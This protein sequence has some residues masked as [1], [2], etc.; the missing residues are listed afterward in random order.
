VTEAVASQVIPVSASDGHRWELIAR[1]PAR[2]VARVLW[3]PALGVPARN[4]LPLADALAARGVACYVHEWRGLGASSLRASR[5]CNWSY[6]E[7]LTMDLPA[8]E[9]ALG[10]HGDGATRVLGGHSLGGQLA[11]CLLALAPARSDAL[12][13]VGSGSPYWHAFPPPLRFALPIAYRFL[14]WLAQRCGA[15][16]GPRVGFGGRE[17]R[18]VIRDWSR[19]A[20]SGRY[21]A[22]GAADLDA[23]MAAIKVP[24]RAVVMDS[25]WMAP[26]SS[27]AFLASK[28]PRATLHVTTLDAATLGTRS[29]HFSWMRQPD[30]VA[31]ALLAG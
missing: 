8:S 10:A 2:P 16:P 23:R 5:K 29:D 26:R 9:A 19:S 27:L 1:V 31:D 25:D 21:R 7:L 3:L 12:W 28:M 30:A 15:L 18:D 17:A 14:P 20:M 22:D 13:L 11:T 4:Y 6:R 24:V